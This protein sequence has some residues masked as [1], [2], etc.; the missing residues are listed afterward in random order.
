MNLNG[1]AVMLKILKHEASCA[2]YTL[3]EVSQ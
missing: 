2:A 1:S 3:L